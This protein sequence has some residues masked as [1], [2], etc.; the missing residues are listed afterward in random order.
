MVETWR[1]VIGTVC[2][3][4]EGVR[5]HPETLWASGRGKPG[6]A[7]G[8][9]VGPSGFHSV[10]TG[11]LCRPGSVASEGPGLIAVNTS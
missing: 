5:A 2:A 10:L 4:S 3:G 7:V 6:T 8:L 1:C 9:S 11:S